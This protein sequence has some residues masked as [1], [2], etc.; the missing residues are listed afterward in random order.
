MALVDLSIVIVTRNT[1]ALLCAALRSAMESR[2]AFTKRIIVVDNGSTDDTTLVVRR[3]FPAVKLVCAP[4][5]LGF[6][7]A[8]NL[9]AKEAEGE[10]LLLLNSDAR[11]K[12]DTLTAAVDWMPEAAWLWAA[13]W[14]WP[15]PL[16]TTATSPGPAA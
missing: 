14:C 6:A 12:P 13:A 9:G 4:R 7:R 10:W 5:N 16:I 11:L 2:D 3:E 8:N 1:C 15:A